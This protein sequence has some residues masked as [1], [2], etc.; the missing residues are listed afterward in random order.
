MDTGR[1]HLVSAEQLAA[2]REAGEDVGA[3][4]EVPTRLQRAALK[5]LAGRREAIVS[6][7]SGGKLSKWAAAERKRAAGNVAKKRTSRRAMA[8]ATRKANRGR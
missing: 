1:N 2:L 4:Q 8:K 6:K 5:K 3:Y 7:T